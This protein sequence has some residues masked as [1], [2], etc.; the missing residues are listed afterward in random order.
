MLVLYKVKW[1]STKYD[2][3]MYFIMLLYINKKG[4]LLLWKK[5]KKIILH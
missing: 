4:V 1:Y 3:I 5:L 2:K